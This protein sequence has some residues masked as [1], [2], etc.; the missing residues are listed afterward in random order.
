MCVCSCPCCSCDARRLV[1]G[2]PADGQLTRRTAVQHSADRL[3]LVK[4][5]RC[6]QHGERSNLV[7][8][9]DDGGALAAAFT[10]QDGNGPCMHATCM[11]QHGT[12]LRIEPKSKVRLIS[13][14][15]THAAPSCRMLFLQPCRYCQKPPLQKLGPV[16]VASYR[17]HGATATGRVL[18][19]IAD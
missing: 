8:Q 2:A 11:K 4:A 18:V 19:L 13:Y 17:G 5:E 6:V 3:S 16:Y 12:S 9:R 14:C 10:G 7:A 1:N 15:H